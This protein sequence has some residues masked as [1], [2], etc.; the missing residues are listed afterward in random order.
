M[1]GPCK[2]SSSLVIS[3]ASERLEGAIYEWREKTLVVAVPDE[4]GARLAALI[5]MV[6][7]IPDAALART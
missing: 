1:T 7:A 3:E 4:P 6:D 5:A 2:A